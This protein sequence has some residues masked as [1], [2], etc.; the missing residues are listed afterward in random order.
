[1]SEK[2]RFRPRV[3]A[4]EDRITP[5]QQSSHGGDVVSVGGVLAVMPSA[6]PASLRTIQINQQVAEII[7]PEG[8]VIP[9]HGLKTAEAHT[10]V[11]DWMPT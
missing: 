4:F 5:S 2:N 11:V 7:L 3:E 9:G 6:A 10:P 8:D 1:M